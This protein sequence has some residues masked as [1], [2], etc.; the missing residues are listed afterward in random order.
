MAQRI[1]HAHCRLG[2]CRFAFAGVDCEE[3]LDMMA[4][5]DEAFANGPRACQHGIPYGNGQRCYGCWPV[6][7]GTMLADNT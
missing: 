2:Q 6:T 7:L 1:K 5:A 4:D 3:Y